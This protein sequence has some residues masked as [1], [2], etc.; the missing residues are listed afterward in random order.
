MLV[1]IH[2]S[3]YLPWLRYFEKV[4][5]SEVFIVLDNIQ[6]SKNGW[7]NRNKIKGPNGPLL[8][9]VPVYAKAG[10]RLDE[11]RINNTVDWRRKHWR[12]IEQHYR[13]APYFA[14]YA[15]FLEAAYRREWDALVELNDYLFR[16]FLDALGIT[17]PIE[18]SSR[19][20]VPGTATERL[21]NLIRAVGGDAYYSGVYALDVYL[22]AHALDAAGIRLELQHWCAPVYPQAYGEFASDLSIVDLLMH[23]GPGSLGVITSGSVAR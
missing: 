13:N 7:Q 2:Q 20:N 18:Y 8:L 12:G 11:V 1:G 3:H 6:F 4:H 15:P 23:R 5:R 10:Q 22:D 9:T 19:L 16:F 17:T 21:I 14:D